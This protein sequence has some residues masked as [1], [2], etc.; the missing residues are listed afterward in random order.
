MDNC[1]C[2]ELD[3]QTIRRWQLI[4]CQRFA[5]VVIHVMQCRVEPYVYSRTVWIMDHNSKINSMVVLF[6][7]IGAD[8]KVELSTGDFK[9]A[10]MVANRE[11]RAH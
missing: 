8:G 11:T 4:G 1:A 3:E 6:G 5:N 2:L 10:V 9:E 7:V